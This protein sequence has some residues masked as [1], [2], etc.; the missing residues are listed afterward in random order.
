MEYV[1]GRPLTEVNLPKNSV[2]D[3]VLELCDGVSQLHCKGIIHRDIKP[4]NILLT[5]KGH[6]KLIDFDA[7]RIKKTEQD[8]D[9]VFVGTD[10]FAPPEQYGFMQT[11]ER[12]DIYALGVTIKLLLRENYQK[13]HLRKIAE[14]C[15]R[16]NPE[17]RYSDV[18]A[19]KS[20]VSRGGMEKW[21]ALGRTLAVTTAVVLLAVNKT[22][23]VSEISHQ[24]EVQ[25]TTAPVVTSEQTTTT[26]VTVASESTTTTVQTTATKSV[27]SSTTA[28]EITTQAT[29]TANE[30]PCETESG[31]GLL[32]ALLLLPEN[33][34]KL[35]ETLSSY[36][37]SDDWIEFGWECMNY[38]QAENAVKLLE[39]WLVDYETQ[40]FSGR[41]EGENVS[42]LTFNDIYEIAFDR[43]D[44][45]KAELV[46]RYKTERRAYF[47]VDEKPEFTVPAD[48][49]RL[50]DWSE[51]DFLPKGFPK[52]TNG[53]TDA[54]ENYDNLQFDRISWDRMTRA[55][56][57]NI[58]QKIT[59]WQS[60]WKTISMN[61]NNLGIINYRWHTEDTFI[62]LMRRDDE[63][64][65]YGEQCRI[66]ISKI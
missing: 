1:E 62:S 58:I 40:D 23:S 7:A 57:A 45:G 56:L 44:N 41:F 55:E 31:Q 28:A 64:L 38:E 49:R 42:I 47:I 50:I 15:M 2:K 63:W 26:A 37:A 43:Y 36:E 54:A 19:V 48:S 4:S 46:V 14:K 21:V 17:D 29:T 32:W 59:P 51:I 65:E 11:D 27:T 35:S 39:N 16:F 22:E 20:A 25:T 60:D 3:I 34:P 66:D 9:T 18:I 8:K 33:F 61:A 12:S 13:S 10:G 30:L 53:V 24:T 6:I 5:D 52:L